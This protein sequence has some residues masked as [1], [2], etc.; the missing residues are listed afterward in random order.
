M[1]IFDKLFGAKPKEIQL[2]APVAGEAIVLDGM[3][4]LLFATYKSH[5]SVHT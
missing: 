2:G 1:G 5:P 4:S 3:C